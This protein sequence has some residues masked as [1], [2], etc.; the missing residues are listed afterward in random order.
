MLE[1]NKQEISNTSNSLVQQANG[2]IYNTGLG[3]KDV[4]D[5]C[6]DVVRQELDIVTKEALDSYKKEV[7]SFQNGLGN[8][9]E[10]L[11]NA[12]EKIDK[13]KLPK[14]Q[15]SL[16]ETINEYAKSDNSETKEELIDLF[17][18]RLKVEENSIEQYL[19]DQSIK[20]LPNLS[21]SQAFFLGALTTRRIIKSGN[22]ILVIDYL[23]NKA[24]MFKHLQEISQ[25]DIHYLK[26]LNC[27]SLLPGTKHH[28]KVLVDLKNNYN[29]IFRHSISAEIYKQ[30][31]SDN[32]DFSTVLNRLVYARNEGGINSIHLLYSEKKYLEEVLKKSDKLE[33][34]PLIE[35]L[36]EL[37]RPFNDLE[38]R[39]YLISLNDNW[40]YAF[41][42]LDKEELLTLD[43]SPVGTYIGRRMIIKVTKDTA[44]PLRDFYK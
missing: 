18:E 15:L 19:I 35:K 43:L 3:Y 24:H 33:K 5:I 26:L 16:H 11:E 8:R 23:R 22:S 2:N 32:S 4:K 34:L 27:C 29:L 12:Q 36:I 20:I 9:I 25:I 10:K 31:C 17:I 42:Y 38:I 30:Y 1:Q 44:L 21:V 13:L 39:N 28:K 41:E 7:N 14:L 6:Q 40:K 37:F